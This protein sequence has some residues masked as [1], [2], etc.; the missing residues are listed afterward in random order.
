MT[1]SRD[2]A[3]PEGFEDAPCPLCGGDDASV[4]VR[5]TDRLSSGDPRTYTVVRCR[6][7]GLGY[8]RPRP[9]PETA[10]SFYPDSYTGGGRSGLVETLEAAYRRRQHREVVDWLAA[11]RPS[12]GLALDVGCGAGDLLVALR[13]DG[14]RVQGLEPSPRGAEQARQ[15]HGLDV[16]T[17]RFETVDL[18]AGAYDVVIFSGVLE[19]LHDPLGALRRARALLAPGGSVAVLFLPML[20]SPEARIFGAR[21]LALDLPRHLTHFDDVTFAVMAARAG[22]DIVAR[23]SYSRRHSA[24]QLVGSLAPGLQKHRFYAAEAAAG[25]A[26]LTTRLAPLAR[27]AAFLAAATAA[28]PAARLAAAAGAAPL[29]SYFLAPATGQHPDPA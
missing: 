27:R 6:H 7:C 15:M 5:A 18:P 3:P 19:H 22:L 23:E 1:A 11:R 17:G 28:R 26:R 4:V 21:W 16:A 25:Q 9:A 29:R 10:G 14:W 24:A 2:I 13:E 20:D 12:R 8:L